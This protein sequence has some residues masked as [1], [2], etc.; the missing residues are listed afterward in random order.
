MEQ[1]FQY[2]KP[3]LQS[4]TG[5]EF[6]LNPKDMINNDKIYESTNQLDVMY[7]LP[8]NELF[9]VLFEEN[10]AIVDIKRTISKNFTIIKMININELYQRHFKFIPEE[11]KGTKNVLKTEFNAFCYKFKEND[12]NKIK[13]FCFIENKNNLKQGHF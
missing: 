12:L 9:I 8:L 4:E 2:K 11:K 3:K 13:N 10:I 1:F 6:Y 5:E 7:Y